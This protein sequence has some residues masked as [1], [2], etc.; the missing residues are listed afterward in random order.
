MKPSFSIV[1]CNYNYA[2]FLGAALD[3]ALNQDWPD[4]EVIAVDD[5]STDDS[6]AILKSYQAANSSR[7]HVI[8]HGRNRGQAAAFNSAIAE[9]HGDFITFLDSDDIMLTHKLSTL[10]RWIEAA[11]PSFGVVQHLM[12][13]HDDQGCSMGLYGGHLLAGDLR[14]QPLLLDQQV[15]P[16]IGLTLARPLAK[17]LCPIPES[18]VNGADSYL[19]ACAALHSRFLAVPLPL[20]IYRIHGSNDSLINARHHA[21]E[22]F[23]RFIQPA[24][25]AHYAEHQCHFNSHS[26]MQNALLRQVWS[27]LEST[28]EIAIYGAG[29]H[30]AKLARAVA[31]RHG[32]RVSQVL[33]D[34]PQGKPDFF[35]VKIET[36]DQLRPGLP[37]LISS[38]RHH[39]AMSRRARQLFPQVTLINPY[40]E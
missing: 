11:G 19:A 18:I 34:Q 26:K 1:I 35:G 28:A 9:A 12:E 37:L 32:P 8:S 15:L 5:G 40:E 27:R 39:Q 10:A 29:T 25:E 6:V 4:F 31:G 24:I 2:R 33:D 16:T 36:L 21:D 14:T 7:L 30:T 3:S 22:R 38:D 20:A 17:R 23:P 13:L